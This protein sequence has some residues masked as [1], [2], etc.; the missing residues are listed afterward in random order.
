MEDMKKT[1]QQLACMLGCSRQMLNNSLRKLTMDGIIR[2]EGRRIIVLKP[3][4]LH[5]L[6][7]WAQQLCSFLKTEAS[8]S[9]FTN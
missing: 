2:T 1:K 8:L 6:R 9:C 7:V 4:N 5:T 3:E